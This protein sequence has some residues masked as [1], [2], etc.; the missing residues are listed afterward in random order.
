[1]E[2]WIGLAFG[3]GMLLR[4]FAAVATRKHARG[5]RF[6]CLNGA[7]VRVGIE[8]DV[9]RVGTSIGAEQSLLRKVRAVVAP[10]SVMSLAP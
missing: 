7:L 8:R 10:K 9:R 6:S 3:K 2:E 5:K 1:M 4:L